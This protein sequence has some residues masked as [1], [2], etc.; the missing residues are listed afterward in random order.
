MIS[1]GG[2]VL[3]LWDV[4]CD[5]GSMQSVLCVVSPYGPQNSRKV[6]CIFVLCWEPAWNTEKGMLVMWWTAKVVFG[7][8]WLTCP[9][10]CF[11]I[12]VV[13]STGWNKRQWNLNLQVPVFLL[14]HKYN[15]PSV[16]T[17]SSL[18]FYFIKSNMF[19]TCTSSSRA[20]SHATNEV[21]I[22]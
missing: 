22:Y 18:I 11:G 14:L 15:I 2:L 4:W 7:C 5:K 17:Q 6:T 9:I 10:T 21:H 20:S 8:S 12:T 3:G 1:R 19:Q 13:E 16:R